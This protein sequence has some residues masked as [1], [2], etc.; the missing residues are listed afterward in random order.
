[1]GQ[2]YEE[3]ESWTPP[4]FAQLD[5]RIGIG[6]DEREMYTEEEDRFARVMLVTGGQ[7]WQEGATAG[8]EV[9]RSA[10]YWRQDAWRQAF[11][12][13]MVEQLWM[14]DLS[15]QAADTLAHYVALMQAHEPA[16][17]E[18]TRDALRK[19]AI[20]GGSPH[21]IA[22]AAHRAVA[23]GDCDTPPCTPMQEVYAGMTSEDR[24]RYLP[25]ERYGEGE[26][27]AELRRIAQGPAH[28]R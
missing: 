28:K 9:L 24:E 3:T 12:F 18:L 23:R 8:R 5:R 6:L 1:V 16:R 14:S 20:D 17:F 27:L 25:Y 2:A 10:P 11:E 13:L 26:A 7:T 19:A 21:L 15:P 4:K 22:E